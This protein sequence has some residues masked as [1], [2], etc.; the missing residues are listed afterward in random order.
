MY[1]HKMSRKRSNK[2]RQ[3][4]EKPCGWEIRVEEGLFTL[5]SFLQFEF[6]VIPN[7]S[8]SQNLN[9]FKMLQDKST[10]VAQLVE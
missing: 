3:Q 2:C 1:L 4:G 8:S 7:I 10:R 6:S 9:V 5:C